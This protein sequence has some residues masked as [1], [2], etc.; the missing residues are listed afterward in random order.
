MHALI[1]EVMILFVEDKCDN[2]MASKQVKRKKQ[3]RSRGVTTF[4]F[5]AHSKM[6]IASHSLE[7]A[8]YPW[9][10]VYRVIVRTGIPICITKSH[11]THE[12]VEW[13]IQNDYFISD[14]VF[15]KQFEINGD[16]EKFSSNSSSL[17]TQVGIFRQAGRIDLVD[18]DTIRYD[19]EASA[20]RGHANDQ[21]T[22][23]I[24]QIQERINIWFDKKIVIPIP[25]FEG[26]DTRGP[27]EYSNSRSDELVERFQFLLGPRLTIFRTRQMSHA[28]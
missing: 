20:N 3:S 6:L 7:I 27:L 9:S 12:K 11:T 21:K 25:R 18:I 15:A 8:S 5:E 4:W 16:C 10:S 17:L 14:F 22:K 28:R 2:I 24:H 19:T 1:S 13:S 23:S 26:R